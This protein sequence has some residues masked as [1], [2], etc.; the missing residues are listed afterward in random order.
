MMSRGLKEQKSL[1]TPWTRVMGDEEGTAMQFGNL[2]R[3]WGIGGPGTDLWGTGFQPLYRETAHS[4][5]L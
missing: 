1:G 3:G 4:S 2:S 5:S